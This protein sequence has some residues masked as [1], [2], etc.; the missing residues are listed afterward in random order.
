V[1]ETS[2]FRYTLFLSLSI[3][4]SDQCMAKPRRPTIVATL[5]TVILHSFMAFPQVQAGETGSGLPHLLYTGLGISPSR[6]EDP[7]NW[8]PQAAPNASYNVTFVRPIAASPLS[9]RIIL[10][11][12]VSAAVA[13]ALELCPPPGLNITINVLRGGSLQVGSGA[14]ARALRVCTHSSLNLHGD[15]L[16]QGGAEV[17]RAEIAGRLE[18]RAMVR[19]NATG[20]ATLFNFANVVFRPASEGDRDVGLENVR[21]ENHGQIEFNR[22]LMDYNIKRPCVLR[23][24]PLVQHA[25]RTTLRHMAY[26]SCAQQ[27][28]CCIQVRAGTLDSEW[29]GHIQEVGGGRAACVVS[30]D[31]GRLEPG[32]AGDDDSPAALCLDGAADRPLRLGPSAH[33]LSRVFAIGLIRA[34]EDGQAGGAPFAVL[35]AVGRAGVCRRQTW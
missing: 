6:W 22:A 11:E 13:G 2:L 28:E 33:V 1:Y 20:G 9:G 16:I 7:G 17:V 12:I 14:A 35:T 4:T 19:A 3:L 15:L 10:L 25:G 24:A 8:S 26:I 29:R 18:V 27:T 34:R 23:G 30:V 21:L 32:G 31:R 5:L